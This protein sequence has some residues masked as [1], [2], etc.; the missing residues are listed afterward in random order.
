MV[1]VEII[2]EKEKNI[3]ENIPRKPIYATCKDSELFWMI[4]F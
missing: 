2:T 3:L 4:Q 1:I